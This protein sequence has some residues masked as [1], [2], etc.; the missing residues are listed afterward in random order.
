MNIGIMTTW[1]STCGIAEYS[2][3]LIKSFTKAGNKVFIFA[4]RSFTAPSKFDYTN[5]KV[6]PE[7]FG[8][9]WWGESPTIELE[10]IVN[11]IHDYSIDVLYIQYHGSLYAPPTF[12]LL[13]QKVKQEFNIPIFVTVHDSSKHKNHFLPETLGCIDCFIVHKQGVTDF[14]SILIP[15]PIP[16]VAPKAISFGLGRNQED[17][18]G[19]VCKSLGILYTN[20]DAYKSKKWLSQDELFDLIRA[21]DVVI[22]WYNEVGNLIGNSFA[23]RVAI[24]SHRPVI[25]NDIPWFSGLPRN[26]FYKVK[27]TQELKDILDEV[28]HLNYINM[29][30]FDQ[31]AKRYLSLYE[32]YRSKE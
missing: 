18:I 25:V 4:N 7:C 20:H 5:V 32:M 11:Y 27:N 3:N 16:I 13:I 30:S 22:L 19:S 31:A 26:I 8:V 1:A 10:N 17:F 15:Y 9:Y 24:A 28:L 23:A 14:P 29:Y 21:H 12:D 6:F 2:N